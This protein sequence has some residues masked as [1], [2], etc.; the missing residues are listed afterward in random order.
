MRF[1]HYS[2]HTE[3]T[4]IEWIRQYV[5]H[6]IMTCRRDLDCGP[7]KIEAFLTYLTMGRNA[8]PSTQNQTMCALVFLYKN[9]LKQ[10]LEGAIDAARA[11]RKIM[12][13]LCC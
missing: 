10:P 1:H 11:S 4:Y 7:A 13:L 9:I 8:S 3:R 6:H 2:I 12:C 5:R